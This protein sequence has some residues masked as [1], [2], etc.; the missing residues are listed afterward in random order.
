[1]VEPTREARLARLDETV[2]YLCMPAI[3]GLAA[4][5][6]SVCR[7]GVDIVQVRDSTLEAREEL[8]A[9][10]AASRPARAASSMVAVNNRADLALI[11]RADILH[12]GQTDLSPH[13][14]RRVVGPDMLIG[15]STHTPEQARAA[16]SDPDVDYF[17]AGPVYATPTK[18]DRDPVGLEMVEAAAKHANGKPWFA[19]GGVD[20]DTIDDVIDAGAERIVVVRAIVEAA[21]PA[22]MAQQLRAK[23]F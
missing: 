22:A 4:F 6:D 2:L 3:P 8:Q 15:A 9:V 18:P 19:I 7:A 20:L 13:D 23:L 1:M 17:C 16:A 10:A 5:V 12:L 14:A 21:D 11:G